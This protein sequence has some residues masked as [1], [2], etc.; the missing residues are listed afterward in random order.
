MR[1]L[2]WTILLLLVLLL[3]A[4]GKKGPVRPLEV[5]RP[6]PATALELRQQG[7]ALLLSWQ[8]PTGNLDGS[9]LKTPPTLDVYRMTFEPENDCPECFDRSTLL[10]RIAADLPAPAI[11]VGDRY[12]LL[13]RQV[14]DGVGYQYKLVP[15]DS[16]DLSGPAVILR[17]VF[18]NPVPAPQQP[19]VIP[20]DRAVTLKWQSTA[21]GADDKLLGYQI[22]RQVSG[23]ARSPYPLNPHPLQETVFEDFSLENGRSYSYWIRTL[24]ERQ[25]QTVEGIASAELIAVP[26]ADR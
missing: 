14:Q 3:S 11:K 5:Q 7:A 10:A 2:R 17:Q 12:L 8:L 25:Q 23:E 22:Y 19:V 18:S 24:V 20:R 15:R 21:L 6:G 4:C 1:A 9:A 26:Q 16:D 13:D